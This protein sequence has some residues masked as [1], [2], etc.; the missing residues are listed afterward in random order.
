MEGPASAYAALGLAP[1]AARDEVERAYRELIKRHH[2]DRSGGDV[3]RAAEI[4]RAYRELR[5]AA[6]LPIEAP[7]RRRRRSRGRGRDGARS[8]G[9][10]ILVMAVA[11]LALLNAQTISELLAS[12]WRGMDDALTPAAARTAARA[13]LTSGSIDDPLDEQAVAL[14]VRDAL[15]QSPAGGLTEQ[16]RACHRRLREA[17]SIGRFDRCAAFDIAAS[18]LAGA[19]EAQRFGA[20]ELTA[21]QMNAANLLSGDFLAIERRLDQLRDAV[22]QRL[23]PP[24]PPPVSAAEPADGSN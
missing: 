7:V 16:S 19:R 12:G 17:P 11:G 18:E 23:R 22:E 4:N 3:A 10:P 14:G 13:R 2:P 20:S 24:P 15:A 21:R 1:G 5:Q 6:E 9:G 8:P